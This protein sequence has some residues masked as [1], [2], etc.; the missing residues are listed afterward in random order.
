[1]RRMILLSAIAA[2]VATSAAAQEK[3]S[4]LRVAYDGYSMTTAR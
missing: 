3:L 2:L 1:M 4:K